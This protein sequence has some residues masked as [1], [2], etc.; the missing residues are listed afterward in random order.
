MLFKTDAQRRAAFSNMNKFAAKPIDVQGYTG[1]VLVAD[2]GGKDVPFVVDE[3]GHLHPV[4]DTAILAG[5]DYKRG[6]LEKLAKEKGGLDYQHINLGEEENKELVGDIAMAERMLGRP[7][8]SKKNK[9]ATRNDNLWHMVMD[10]RDKRIKATSL[11]IEK[12]AKLFDFVPEFQNQVVRDL[13]VYPMYDAIG[14]WLDSA[15]YVDDSTYAA[16][17]GAARLYLSEVGK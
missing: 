2:T 12:Y 1:S 10:T 11:D 5:E 17:E 6:I 9:F 4:R 13:R 8:Y 16:I 15:E 7:V 14:M 3:Y